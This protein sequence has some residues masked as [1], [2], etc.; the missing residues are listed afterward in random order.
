MHH[1][2]IGEISKRMAGIDI[3][4]LSTH[5]E[6]GQIANRP[7]SNN[8]DVEYDGT[9]YYFT[10]EQARTVADIQANPIVALGFTG[11]GGIFS[12]RFTWRSKA[13]LN[14]SAIRLHSMRTGQ[15]V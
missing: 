14:S 12:M 6:G 8:G 2:T 7:M 13:A 11:E 10:Y 15:T 1:K 3:A 5:T 9:S 4:V